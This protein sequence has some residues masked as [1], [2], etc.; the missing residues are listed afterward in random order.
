MS[1]FDT[2]LT[3]PVSDAIGWT[4]FHSLWQGVL[5]GI[6]AMVILRIQHRASAQFRYLVGVISLTA[7]LM[8]SIL[9]FH[10]EYQPGTTVEG[11]FT[12]LQSE[13]AGTEGLS[14]G[15]AI[16][17]GRMGYFQEALSSSF[18][19]M[20]TIWLL[21]VF[22]LSVRLAGGFFHVNRLRSRGV[23]PLSGQLADRFVSLVRNSGI[24]RKL[25][26]MVSQ[27]ISVTMVIGVFKPVI[28]IPAGIISLMPIEQL[29][30]VVAHEIAHIR[31]YDFLINIF[32]SLIEALFFYHPVVWLLSS[33]IRQEREKCC[34]DYAMS[35][36][37]RLSIYARALAG[38]GEFQARTVI[39]AVAL[40]G[41][42]NRVLNRVERL[43]NPKKM[44]NNA[45]EKIIAGLLILG[46]AVIMTLSTGASQ[47]LKFDL[48]SL[49][50]DTGNT[51]AEPEIPAEPAVSAEPEQVAGTALSSISEPRAV[52]EIS[53]VSEPRIVREVHDSLHG[54]DLKNMDIKDNVVMQE[55]ITKD[56]TGKSM[57]FVIKKGKVEELYVDGKKIP[58]SDHSSYQKEIDRTM[59]DLQ[60]MEKELLEARHELEDLD[61]EEMH[62]EMQFEMQ[63]FKQHEMKEIQEEMKQLQQEQFDIQ[64]DEKE[65]QEE[66][67][68][69]MEEIEI[70]NED[71]RKEMEY[72]MQ[73][74][75][76]HK[77][78]E[79]A[80]SEE[81]FME[82]EKAMAEAM[83]E[84][85][86]INVDEMMANFE[87]ELQSI[88]EFDHQK[89]QKEIE[90]AMKELE[91]IDF[92]E[93]EKQMQESMMQMEHEKINME[94]ELRNIDELIEELEKL[95]LEK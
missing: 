7:V 22:I 87:K 61:W 36:C 52:H 40:S 27:G 4:I 77:S 47:S 78:G 34:D 32:Q 80:K 45:N 23:S 6:L 59:K 72:A 15:M 70:N 51:Y 1:F 2:F 26:F 29:E 28:L 56:G 43:I 89:M 16:N 5:I 8:A 57:K 62:H 64:I 75:E 35:V 53:A 60:T 90:M 42:K 10:L 81:E 84:L 37:G 49:E 11:G 63:H 54:H 39:P 76:K 30:A 85:G 93:I 74:M 41:N 19:W 44:K 91:N 20:T 33:H 83:E 67:T 24:R 38:L 55:F 94:K 58:E 79:H 92:A 65:M 71:M 9:T 14:T 88:Q 68:R 82:M 46:S 18:P 3:G 69:A 95:E 66:I 13:L 25:S 73:A 31:R 86:N 12:L 48:T 17:S 50:K 21:G